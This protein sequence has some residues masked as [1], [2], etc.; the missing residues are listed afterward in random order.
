MKFLIYF[1]L[2]KITYI[3]NF[4]DYFMPKSDFNFNLTLKNIEHAIVV[5]ASRIIF[6]FGIHG[7]ILAFLMLVIGIYGQNQ[8]KK[9][10]KPFMEVAKK[11]FITCFI[12]MIPGL[13]SL[14]I[15]HNIPAAGVYN[16]NSLGYLGL[17]S[18]ITA[19]LCLEEMNFEWFS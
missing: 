3:Q 6:D 10:G 11:L 17:W 18:L 16:I 14:L 7:L 2:T 1:C 13:I 15:H 19:Y 12:F 9:Y 5:V 4:T 8:S